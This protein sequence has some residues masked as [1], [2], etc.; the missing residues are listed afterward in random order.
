MP[1]LKILSNSVL[2]GGGMKVTKTG[3]QK[4]EKDGRCKIDFTADFNDVYGV[5]LKDVIM[6]TG[7]GTT[8]TESSSLIGEMVEITVNTFDLLA[9]ANTTPLNAFV[10]LIPDSAMMITNGLRNRVR[11]DLNNLEHQEIIR[12][13]AE[14]VTVS[15]DV[16]TRDIDTH[17]SVISTN[18][19]EKTHSNPTSSNL[20][21]VVVSKKYEPDIK[22][23]NRSVSG[24]G[25]GTTSRIFNGYSMEQLHGGRVLGIIMLEDPSSYKSSDTRVIKK[26]SGIVPGPYTFPLL[27]P[28]LPVAVARGVGSTNTGTNTINESTKLCIEFDLAGD[29]TD[30][31]KNMIIELRDISDTTI[32]VVSDT[33]DGYELIIDDYDKCKV[34]FKLSDI[35]IEGPIFPYIQFGNNT[36]SKYNKPDS[37]TAPLIFKKTNNAKLYRYD[38]IVSYTSISFKIYN[39]VSNTDAIHNVVLQAYTAGDASVVSTES[40]ELSNNTPSF[41]NFI[42]VTIEGLTERTDYNL[43][44]VVTDGTDNT[45]YTESIG[46]F[47]TLTTDVTAPQIENI[48]ARGYTNSI[49]FDAEINDP[50]TGIKYIRYITL[51]KTFY[52]EIEDPLAYISELESID[53]DCGAIITINTE[54]TFRH[55][56]TD[57]EMS[58]CLDIEGTS[59]AITHETDYVILIY[60][61]DYTGIGLSSLGM[62]YVRTIVDINMGSIQVSDTQKS[63]LSIDATGVMLKTFPVDIY[64]GICDV[65]DTDNITIDNIKIWDNIITQVSTETS[66]QSDT[67]IRSGNISK[68]IKDDLLSEI[69]DTSD[70]VVFIYITPFQKIY[71]SLTTAYSRIYKLEHSKLDFTGPDLRNILVNFDVTY[72]E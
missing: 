31:F 67:T 9:P 66:I 20:Q 53:T 14:P 6:Q 33:D 39:F 44:Y 65:S 21:D 71:P 29:A 72:S 61:I 49:A 48:I 13:F 45:A 36:G 55:I 50:G 38:E 57:I 54:G 19:F 12:T 10:I 27:S 63:T 11:L 30:M 5:E 4:I 8:F 17:S 18:D 25:F 1:L 28:V 68:F 37:D 46:G 62:V 64:A 43:R 70:Y 42:N 35:N 26:V 59:P 23:I 32:H 41:K 16:D 2:L 52:D 3:K 69:H 60:A 40:F 34:I 56:L 51:T 22:S 24:T 15:N 47:K 58:K 7:D